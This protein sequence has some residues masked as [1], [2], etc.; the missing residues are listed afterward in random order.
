M[1]IKALCTCELY[2]VAQNICAFSTSMH[3][4]L[5]E[6][7]SM[8]VYVCAQAANAYNVAYDSV[9]TNN[10]YMNYDET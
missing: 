5:D 1:R 7:I 4:M 2:I 9:S 3:L 8:F 10:S 6:Y